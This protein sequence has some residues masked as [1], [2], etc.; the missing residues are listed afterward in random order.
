MDIVLMNFA[1]ITIV[2]IIFQVITVKAGTDWDFLEKLFNLQFIWDGDSDI[3]RDCD[4]GAD[5]KLTT[6]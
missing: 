1:F 4:G 6:L 5:G 2:A 3:G